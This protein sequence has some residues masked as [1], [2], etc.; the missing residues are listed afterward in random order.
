MDNYVLNRPVSDGVPI[1]RSQRSRIAKSAL[2]AEVI[3]VWDIHRAGNMTRD[4]VDGF[5][6]AAIPVPFADVDHQ[7]FL[8]VS[9]AIHCFDVREGKF[10]TGDGVQGRGSP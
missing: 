9:R 2:G 7:Q 1:V 4:G 6:F 10:P 5:T 3:K 8:F